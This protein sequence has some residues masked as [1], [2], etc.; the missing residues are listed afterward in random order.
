MNEDMLFLGDEDIFS[1]LH[2]WAMTSQKSTKPKSIRS[3]MFS[4]NDISVNLKSVLFDTGALHRS[5]IHSGLV[6]NNRSAW[7]DNIVQRKSQIRLGDQ[8]TVVTSE[9]E[10]MGTVQFLNNI[11]DIVESQILL[12]VHD[13]PGMD[14]IIGLPDISKH[15]LSLLNEMLSPTDLSI[16][17]TDSLQQLEEIPE[18]CFIWSTASDENSP[19]ELQTEEPCSHSAFLNFISTGHAEAVIAYKDM[20]DAHIGPMLKESEKIKQLMRSDLALEVFVPKIWKGIQ[21]V[22]PIQ[23]EVD[24]TFPSTHK[25]KSRPINPRLYENVKTEVDSR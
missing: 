17:D 7:S 11:G 23:I 6:N 13:M 8:K 15:F 4:V 9:E 3:G 14:M 12:V 19:E 18:G 20:L 2:L 24:V 21:G 22:P 10:I 16:L 25:I 1:D 5:Y